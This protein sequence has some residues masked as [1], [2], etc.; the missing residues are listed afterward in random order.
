MN[1]ITSQIDKVFL[2]E[3]NE[4]DTAHKVSYFNFN[5]KFKIRNQLF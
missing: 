1:C 4:D 2:T 5:K 3:L